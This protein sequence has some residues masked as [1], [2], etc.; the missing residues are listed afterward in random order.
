MFFEHAND[1][2]LWKCWAVDMLSVSKVASYWNPRAFNKQ[3]FNVHQRASRYIIFK[4]YLSR[5]L[6]KK[7]WNLIWTTSSLGFQGLRVFNLKRWVAGY[8]GPNMVC[9]F[10]GSL[11][12]GSMDPNMIYVCQGSVKQARFLWQRYK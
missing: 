10:Q 3:C 7:N 11:K 6:V 2:M 12:Y 8:L 9:V 1:V 5:F 4:S